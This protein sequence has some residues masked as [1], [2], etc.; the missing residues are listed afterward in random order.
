M[1]DTTSPTVVLGLIFGGVLSL[2]YGV[3]L[4]TDAMQ[5]D[6]GTRL[7]RSLTL[8]TRYPP[9][10]FGVGIG[11]T[12]LTQSSGATSS[13]LVGL[14]SVGL[15]TLPTAIIAL[16]GSN[17]GSALIVQLLIF[18]ITDYA[19]VFVGFGALIAMLTHHGQKRDLGQACF[20]FGLVILGLAA[21]EAGSQ[22]LAASQTTLLVLDA[23]VKSPLVLV[24]IGMVL[25][26]AF[27][28]SIAGIGLVIVLASNG[29][30]PLIAAFALMLGSNVGSTVTA[31]LTA[32]S[33]G[34]VAG[35]RLALIHSGTKLTGALA[36]LLFLG[37]LTSLL[38][39][40]ALP[41]ATLVALSHLGFNLALAVLFAPLTRLLATF[42]EKLVPEQRSGEVAVSHY[43]NPDALS[44]PA[45]ALGQAM[46]EILHMT[47]LVTEML[48][49]AIHA[50]EERGND[51]IPRIKA[52]DDQ[53]DELNEAIKRYLTR[54]DEGHM[55]EDQ[56]HR[57]LALFYVI[58][59]LE[60]MGDILDR[61]WMRLARRKQRKQ[62]VFSEQGW[63]DLMSY[64][65]ELTQAVQ[66]AFAAL[67]AQDPRLAGEF[68]A[69][70]RRLGQLKRL[71][72]MQ[73]LR[74]LQSGVL[75]SVESSAIH[76]DLLS[77]MHA[78]LSHASTIA[79]VVQENL[80]V[81]Q[82]GEDEPSGLRPQRTIRG[83]DFNTPGEL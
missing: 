18:H 31:M 32:L 27:A 47:D 62:V 46:R 41:A 38:S 15:L 9:V 13:L 79:H 24:L 21:L 68:F 64:Y 59:D 73:H 22:P 70:K 71:L 16:L 63:Q 49:L 35:R 29:S 76:L 54:L 12:V 74:R 11:I 25:T 72:S 67:A 69:R 50:F 44:M 28:S 43:L 66:E 6:A 80:S 57:Q 53:L 65:Q 3:R 55:T 39:R 1:F 51:V 77:A 14:V 82:V 5:R 37:P 52:L 30:L 45:V 42:G 60:E 75:P 81:R 8:L 17:V 48:D 7:R 58:T 40:T 19:F 83:D 4:I 56:K 23:L 78:I 10:A 33:H 2:L 61:Q 26:M 34:S 36:L 20:G